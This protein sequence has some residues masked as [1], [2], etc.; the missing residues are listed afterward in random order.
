M[1]VEIK[2]STVCQDETSA[3]QSLAGG[4]SVGNGFL[5]LEWCWVLGVGLQRPQISD[6]GGPLAHSGF[7]ASIYR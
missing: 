4:I 1:M 6:L 2:N 5:P 7:I 3:L